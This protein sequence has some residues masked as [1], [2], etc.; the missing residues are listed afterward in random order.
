MSQR[1]KGRKKEEKGVIA[2]RALVVVDSALLQKRW[3][4]ALRNRHQVRVSNHLKLL[5][6][7]AMVV[8]VEGKAYKICQVWIKK[9]SAKRTN[10]CIENFRW[11]QNWGCDPAPRE[12]EGKPVYCL[13]GTRCSVGTS[14]IL[15]RLQNVG[16]RAVMLRE[17][18][19]SGGPRRGKVSKH[20]P[21]AD[22]PVV[23][24]KCL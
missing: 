15:A 7:K 5:W 10:V 14:L 6:T 22:H 20:C 12:V 18:P 4:K 2:P 24:M 21:E 1:E 23:V 11:C 3:R 17:N 16:T 9:V 13:D 19:I 8:S